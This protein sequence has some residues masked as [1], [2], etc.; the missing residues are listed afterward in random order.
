MWTH[1]LTAAS[2]TLTASLA[3]LLVADRLVAADALTD[4][5][6]GGGGGSVHHASPAKPRHREVGAGH[7]RQPPP[8]TAFELRRRAL[9]SVTH[10]LLTALHVYVLVLDAEARRPNII[11]GFSRAA[12]CAAAAS[13]VH[14]AIDA[15]LYAV[16]PQRNLCA[17]T[18]AY[19][20]GWLLHHVAAV[21]G[22]VYLLAGPRK[23]A[24]PISA[25]LVSAAA[26]VPTDLRYMWLKCAGR[27]PRAARGDGG[28]GERVLH[29]QQRRVQQR[30]SARAF[31]LL[32]VASVF[33]ASIVPPVWMLREI[34]REM[35]LPSWR[36]L[37]VRVD[38]GGAGMRWQCVAGTV[39][40][41]APHLGVLVYHVRREFAR[42]VAPAATAK[43]PHD[44]R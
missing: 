6:D 37:M 13:A 8:A 5:D 18:S 31:G 39:A 43:A 4:G 40:V 19:G 10:L 28:D 42:A 44:A 21:L 14:Y 20:L 25:L 15:V 2:V 35:R 16:H 22:L 12:G 17:A 41:M 26:H 34:V 36:Y 1:E 11:T 33:G 29:P 24:V 3:V 9:Q 30:R 32:I 27:G 7:R 38:R 23:G